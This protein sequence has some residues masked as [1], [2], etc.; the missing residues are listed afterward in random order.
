M[1]TQPTIKEIIKQVKSIGEDALRNIIDETRSEATVEKALSYLWD[2]LE[3]HQLLTPKIISANKSDDDAETYRIEGNDCF[4]KRI[5]DKA[6]KYYNL[7]I[8]SAPHPPAMCNM[9]GQELPSYIQNDAS[10]EWEKH[11]I[12]TISLQSG[13]GEY[14]TY[15]QPGEGEYKTLSLGF[16]NR[17]AVLFEL[18]QYDKCL[19][20]IALALKYGHPETVH[21]KLAKRRAQCLIAMGEISAAKEV[22]E[23]ALDEL[24]Y[25]TLDE[26]NRNKVKNSLLLLIEQCS[27]KTNSSNVSGNAFHSEYSVL[28]DQPTLKTEQLLFVYNVPDPVQLADANPS[29][30]AISNSITMAFTPSQGRHLL[31]RGIY[32]QVIY[33]VRGCNTNLMATSQTLFVTNCFPAP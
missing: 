3:T 6:L 20:D 11:Q 15:S 21:C 18:E 26:T 19:S 9:A 33:F 31:A 29:I 27:L 23:A 24:Q 8:L 2:P 12:P 5:L 32:V 25:L 4:Q 14:T 7:S 10:N 13:E 28:S 16:A 1:A 22:L 17:S 30:P